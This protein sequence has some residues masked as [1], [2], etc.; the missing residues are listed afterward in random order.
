MPLYGQT[1]HPYSM[2]YLYYLVLRCSSDFCSAIVKLYRIYY[3]YYL[4]LSVSYYLCAAYLYYFSD[5][6]K[7][8][9]A[10]AAPIHLGAS[11]RFPP[12]LKIQCWRFHSG[13]PPSTVDPP[14]LTCT[15]WLHLTNQAL[16]AYL[17]KPFLTN[18]PSAMSLTW[19]SKPF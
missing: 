12:P 6:T 2:Y 11:H 17:S 19:H 4:V 13:R 5:L 3:L 8:I 1:F 16:Q 10:L 7:I 18:T 15:H 14:A 9:R